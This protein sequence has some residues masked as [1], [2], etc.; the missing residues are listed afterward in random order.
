[1]TLDVKESEIVEAVY[2][3]NHT[4]VS[5][6]AKLDY[7]LEPTLLFHLTEDCAGDRFYFKKN[8]N[9]TSFF[10]YHA[11]TRFKNDFENKQSIFREWEKYKNDIELIHPNSERHHLKI[12]GGFQ[13]STHKSGDEWR[14]FGINHFV[15]PE[16]LVTMEQ[17]QSFITY[18]VEADKFEI[19]T[20]LAIIDR[21]TQKD[22]QPSDEIGDIKRIDDIYKDEWRELVKDTIDILDENKKIVLA[23]KRLIMFDK[24][25]NIPYILNRAMQGEHNSYL[26]VLESQDSVF[27]SQTPEQLME[28]KDDVLSTKAV[29][30]TI[31][32]THR[33][34]IDKA[35][36]DAFLN[37]DKNLNEHHFV[38]KSILNDI[39]PYVE[40]ITFNKKPQ[41]LTNDHLYHLYTKIEGRLLQNSY[42]GLLDNLHPTPALGGYPKEEA[43]SYIENNEFGTRGLYGAPVGYIDM[44]DNCEFI[45]A[46][47]SMLIKK[48]QATLFAGCGIVQNSDADSEVEETAV[49]FNPM[50]KALGVEK[51]E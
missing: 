39:K 33:D 8:D 51:Y 2:E 21:L 49:K 17:G 42:I 6:E 24:N 32:R 41:I 25:I 23:R 27:F 5:V 47:R 15:L 36:I 46:I 13:F 7:E 37:D 29:A 12:C 3:S 28:V 10:G 34:D 50:M 48:N 40:E 26:F 35:N 11:I 44:Y 14:E 18:T 45:V 20:F 1:M 22:V 4:W 30:G 9:E 43:I 19:D 38:V 31:K 16:V